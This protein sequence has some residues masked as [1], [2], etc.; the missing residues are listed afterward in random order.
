VD[1]VVSPA[2][3]QLD[4]LRQP[5]TDGEELVFEFFDRHLSTGWEIYIQP[6]LNGLRPDFVL[7]NPSI[8]IAVFEVKDWNLGAM[9]YWSEDQGGRGQELL[10]RKDGKTFSLQKEN[11]FPKVLRYEREIRDL[12]CPRLDSR[13][14]LAAITSGVVFPFTPEDALGRVFGAWC[15]NGPFSQFP[16]YYTVTG[17]E[18]VR[19]GRIDHVLP[20]HSRRESIVMTEDHAADLR[21]WL[22]EPSFAADQREPL[23]LD[24][25][26]RFLVQNRTASGFRRIKG[27]AGSGKSLVLA[28]RAAEL[29]SAGKEVLVVS[30]N[31]T[32][33][34]YLRDA[35]VRWPVSRQVSHGDTTWLNFHSW[36]RRTAQEGNLEHEYKQAW[37]DHLGYP[38]AESSNSAGG[39]VPNEVFRIVTMA[40]EAESGGDVATYDAI[41]VDE[42]QDFDPEWWNLLRKVLRPGGEMVLVADATQDVY[43]TAR[44]WTDEAMNGAGFS[45][46]PWVQLKE[47]YRLPPV[48]VPYA[49]EFASRYLPSDT[50]DL[51]NSTQTELDVFPCSMRW[52]QTSGYNAVEVCTKEILHLAERFGQEAFAIPDTTFLAADRKSGLAVVEMLA[53]RNVR[54]IHTFDEDDGKAR[55]MKMAFWMGDARVKGTTIHSFKGWETRGLVVFTGNRFGERARAALYTALTRVKRAVEGSHITVVC[56]IPE[57]REFGTSWPAFE[58]VE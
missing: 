18:S 54:A 3:D 40:I 35:F 31:I 16:R 34:H 2:L 23:P 17:L 55:R 56:S 51:P 20:E 32:L 11:P 21:N 13:S 7:L 38:V 28:A 30:F 15:D 24:S 53:A 29:A 41:L 36:M 39:N 19:D 42:G 58:Q 14:G 10:A 8:G 33:L 46:G 6:H 50:V 1:R 45:G 47:S 4:R 26:Q 48:V 49:Q 57:L 25:S 5:L 44:S 12:Y 37:A 27:P 52:V 9:D 22:V 43:G